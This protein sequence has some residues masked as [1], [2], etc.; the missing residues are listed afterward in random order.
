MLII[1]QLNYNTLREKQHL[2]RL[3]TRTTYLLSNKGRHILF[4]WTLKQDY[5]LI[6]SIDL[7]SVSYV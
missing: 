3:I 2:I 4:K 1:W 6:N 5:D 7:N